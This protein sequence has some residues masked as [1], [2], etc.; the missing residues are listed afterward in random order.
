MAVG[1]PFASLMALAPDR[2]VSKIHYLN[3]SGSSIGNWRERRERLNFVSREVSPIF[4]LI[5]IFKY[6]YLPSR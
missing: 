4:T 6:S 3:Q 2:V 5:A 1:S